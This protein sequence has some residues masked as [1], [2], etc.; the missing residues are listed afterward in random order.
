MVKRDGLVDKLRVTA[1]GTGQVGHAG[2]ALLAGTPDR[3]GLTR[4]VSGAMASTRERRSAH[5]PG[6]SS[7]A[8][9]ARP[10]RAGRL[11]L[12]GVSRDRLDRRRLP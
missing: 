3:I 1:D 4:A 9:P 7:A 11:R 8:R 6:S 10:V 12:D 5:D 2:S